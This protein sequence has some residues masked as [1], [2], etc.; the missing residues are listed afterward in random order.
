MTE[1]IKDPGLI[2]SEDLGKGT[3]IKI[4][5]VKDREE[6]SDVFARTIADKIIENNR[7]GRNS[8]FIMPV[9]PT[10]Q[11]RKLASIINR[12][13]IKLSKLYFFNMD[14]YV[15][16]D[17]KNLPADHP[18]SFTRF[19]NEEFLSLIDK[20]LGLKREN[21]HVPDAQNLGHIGKTIEKAGGIDICFAGIGLNGHVAFNEPPDPYENWTDESFSRAPERVVKLATTTKAT[22]AIFGTGGDL[23]SVPDYAVTI[24]MD[25]ILGSRQIQV[26]LDWPWQS[27]I[28]REAIHGTVTK[29]CPASYIQTH[30]N[31]VVTMAGYVA[32]RHPQKPE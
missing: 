31:V 8:T 25:D 6:V 1:K 11:Y 12:E 32:R 16:K 3:H 17:G 24:G 26:F 4:R 22:N 14:E 2:E 15:G 13:K 30:K 9:G 21:F 28:V 23:K 27:R 20:G 18:F 7:D 10:G 5:I 19:V 29:F